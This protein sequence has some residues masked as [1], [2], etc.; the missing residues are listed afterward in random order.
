MVSSRPDPSAPATGTTPHRVGNVPM[1]PSHPNIA[2]A[3][4]ARGRVRSSF[5]ATSSH[6]SIL[7]ALSPA[8]NHWGS[9]E[10]MVKLGTA[11]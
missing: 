9:D 6:P 2:A 5:T 4:R 11:S 7:P 8:T 10:L 3:P 1:T